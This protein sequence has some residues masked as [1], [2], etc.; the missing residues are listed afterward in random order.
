MKTILLLLFMFVHILGTGQN[1]IY[2]NGVWN[3]KFHSILWGHGGISSESTSYSTYQTLGD[4]IIGDS[5]FLKMFK[6]QAFNGLLFSDESKVYYGNNPNSLYLMFDFSLMPGDTF[7]FMAPNYP[8]ILK[9]WVTSVDSIE[10]KGITRKRI[11]FK[12]FSG[13]GLGPQWIE[14]IGDVNFGGI[15]TNYSYVVYDNNTTTLLCYMQNNN[16]IYGTCTLGTFETTRN[17]AIY[18]N[19]THNYLRIELCEFEKPVKV[20]LLN[21]NGK[22]LLEVYCNDNESTLDLTSFHAGMYILQLWD[23]Q[24]FVSKIIVKE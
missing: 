9:S 8:G 7:A 15:E 13:Y 14:G 12:N 24:K 6:N 16:K 22:K 3:Q 20:K 4:T 23:T 11:Q 2:D 19:P 5:I 17:N 1:I 18:P 21:L 10:I